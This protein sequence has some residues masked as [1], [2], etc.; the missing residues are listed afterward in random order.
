M[1]TFC[2]EVTVLSNQ[3]KKAAFK[4]QL[5]DVLLVVWRNLLE[6]LAEAGPQTVPALAELRS[7][8]RQNVQIMVNRLA[9]LGFV[10][11]RPNPEH[12][13][14]GLVCLTEAGRDALA[15]TTGDEKQFYE[16]LAA[17]CSEKEIQR[18]LE[19]I[20]KLRKLMEVDGDEVD[21]TVAKAERRVVPTA[22]PKVE[23]Q[24][25]PVLTETEPVMETAVSSIADETA[26]DENSLPY[27]LL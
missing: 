10:E 17:H 18:G 21:A 20:G 9:R 23:R 3:V 11:L 2:D 27:N 25:E 24:E 26:V 16:K 15:K 12:K 8:S 4:Y 22:R 14:S 6:S 13:K 5:D 1:E 19:L 7:S